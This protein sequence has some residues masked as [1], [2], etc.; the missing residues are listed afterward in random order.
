MIF[1]VF[2]ILFFILVLAVLEEGEQ[3]VLTKVKR[4]TVR[5]L[6]TRREVAVL[7]LYGSR[8]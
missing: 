7:W 5:A 6:L 2:L 4:A 3:S 1:C 8:L